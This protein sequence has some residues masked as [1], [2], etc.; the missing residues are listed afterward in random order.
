VQAFGDRLNVIVGSVSQDRDSVL[1]TLKK[2]AITVRGTRRVEPSLENVFISLLTT[3]ER[4][5]ALT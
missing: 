3:K 2:N 5:G 1:E 4:N